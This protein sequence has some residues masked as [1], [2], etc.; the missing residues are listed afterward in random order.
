MTYVTKKAFPLENN[1]NSKTKD[2]KH[3]PDDSLLGEEELCL[4]CGKKI[5]HKKEFLSFQRMVEKEG[6]EGV[7]VLD[8]NPIFEICSKKCYK[9]LYWRINTLIVFKEEDAEIVADFQKAFPYS[10]KSFCAILNK[11]EN[12]DREL[13]SM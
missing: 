5:N 4:V 11:V 2:F 7:E 3:L 10:T 8:C 6:E 1:Q 9:K 13:N 12:V